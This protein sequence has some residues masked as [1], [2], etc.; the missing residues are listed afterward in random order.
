MFANPISVDGLTRAYPS[1]SKTPWGRGRYVTSCPLSACF[2]DN[3]FK[4]SGK[5]KIICVCDVRVKPNGRYPLGCAEG[6]E[7]KLLRKKFAKESLPNG[8][9]LPELSLTLS[10]ILGSGRFLSCYASKHD[11]MPA[12]QISFHSPQ[13]TFTT[14]SLSTATCF[15][16]LKFVFLFFSATDSKVKN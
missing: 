13:G 9:P 8:L 10:L 12:L 15:Y 6:L 2:R 1:S 5:R 14:I 3:Q 11:Q 16:P 7:P 4:Q